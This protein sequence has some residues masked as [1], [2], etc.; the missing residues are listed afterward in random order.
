M[1]HRPGNDP[2]CLTLPKWVRL[3]TQYCKKLNLRV[4]PRGQAE[5]ALTSHR[6]DSTERAV[7]SRMLCRHGG[8]TQREAA[9]VLG[10]KTG[11]AVSC[12]LRNL[13]EL[14]RSDHQLRRQVERL[15]GKLRS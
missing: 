6:R 7:A 3:F 14:I 10:L 15:H 1:R 4:R 11:G 12:Q 9:R 8:L 2:S 5:K 13:D